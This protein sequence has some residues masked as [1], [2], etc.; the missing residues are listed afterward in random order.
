MTTQRLRFACIQ[1]TTLFPVCQLYFLTFFHFLLLTS[2][3]SDSILYT[4]YRKTKAFLETQFSKNVFFISK[5]YIL[6]ITSL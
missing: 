2:G 6:E 4:E 5:K 1:Y 3:N